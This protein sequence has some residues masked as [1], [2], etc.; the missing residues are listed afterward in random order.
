MRFTLPLVGRVER[1]E[2]RGFA[3]GPEK[4][5]PTTRERDFTVVITPRKACP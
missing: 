3:A 2:G 5:L 4:S 1:S